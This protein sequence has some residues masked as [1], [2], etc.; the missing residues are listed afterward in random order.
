MQ[1]APELFFLEIDIP[2]E[3]RGV[4]MRIGGAFST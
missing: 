1:I 2:I 3:K 4:N